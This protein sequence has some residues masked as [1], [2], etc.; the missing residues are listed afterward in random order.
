MNKVDA[1]L[2]TTFVSLSFLCVALCVL[3]GTPVLAA[4]N[5]QIDFYGTLQNESG[6]NL[7]G[8]YDIV[9]R[10]YDAPTGGTLLSTDTHTVANGNPVAV[11]NG[12]FAVVL[13]SGTGNSL[14]GIDFD[15]PTIYVGLTIASDTE[16]VP[17]ERLTA[18]P[19]AFNA[20]KVDGYHAA[21]LLRYNATGSMTASAADTLL[22]LRQNGI[23][24][25]F[26]LFGGATE[27]LSVLAN[28]R[29]GIGTTTPSR[30]FVVNGDAQFTGGLYDSLGTAGTLGMVLQTTGTTT[31]WVATSTLGISS[32]SGV[33]GMGPAGSIQTG[34]TLTLATSTSV[35]NGL[36]TGLLITGAGNTITYTPTLTGTLGN[37][38]LANSTIAFATGT[39]GSDVNWSTSPVALGGTA[40]LN[41]PNASATARGLLSS[42]DWNTFTGKISSTS[43]DT[44]AE[45]DTLITDMTGV[46]GS[47]SLVLSISPTFTGTTTLAVAIIASSTI[48]TLNLTSALS[49]Q[50]GGTGATSATGARTNLGATT[51][52]SNLFTLANPS[53]QTLIR[54][55]ADNTVS[56]IATSTLGIDLSDTTGSLPFSRLTNYGGTN[57]ILY[58]S[59]AG[60][61]ATS[62]ALTFDG[63]RLLTNTLAVTGTSTFAG[64]M[65]A[66]DIT[67]TGALRDTTNSAGTLGMVLQTTGTSTRWVAT[68]TL[69]IGGGSGDSLFTDGGATTYLTSLTDNLAIGTTTSTAKLA[70]V[71][72]IDLAS[73]NAGISLNGIR[74]FSGSSSLK[75]IQI[76][77]GAGLSFSN[78]LMIGNVAIGFEAAKNASTSSY[79][80]NVLIG[81]QTGMNS[82]GYYDVVIGYQ[83][84][85]NN[86]GGNN[87]AWASNVLIGNQA[88]YNNAGGDNVII[89]ELTGYQ[90]TGTSNVLL[91]FQAGYQN[92]SNDSVF[93]G[94]DAGNSAVGGSENIAIGF[95]AGYSMSGTGSSYLGYAAGNAA[96]GNQNTGIG[97]GALGGV[98]GWYNT[99][100]GASAGNV[101]VGDFNSMTGF[102]SGEHAIG[103]NNILLGSNAGRY[104]FG[105]NTIA[106]GAGAGTANSATLVDN[107]ES[108]Y[109]G[110]NAGGWAIAG[111]NNTFIGYDA[112][113]VAIGTRNVLLGSAAGSNAYATSSVF[114][115]DHA[116][117]LSQSYAATSSNVLI[118]SYSGYDLSG[119][120]YNNIIGDHAGYSSSNA[121][122]NNI[123]GY[124][125][126]YNLN[127]AAF[128][129]LQGYEAG[130]NMLA[131]SNTIAIGY[132]ALYGSGGLYDAKNNIALGYRA[133]YSAQAGANNN[134]LIGYNAGS[135]ILSGKSNIVIG[136]DLSLKSATQSNTM[137][138]G[139]LLYAT[140]LTAT[141]TATSTGKF[142]LGTSSPSAQLTTVGTV[143]FASFGAGTLQTDASGN[144]S[145]SSDERLKDIQSDFT[146]GIETLALI[147]PIQ[148]RWKTSTGYDTANVYT[149]FSAQNVQAVLPEA[150]GKSG[151]GYL[152]LSDRPLLA[153]VIN[154]IKEIYAWMHTTDTRVTTLEAHVTSLQSELDA[155]KAGKTN[156]SEQ[157]TTGGTSTDTPAVTSDDTAATTTVSAP[158]VETI[159]ATTPITE[160]SHEGSVDTSSGAADSGVEATTAAGS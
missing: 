59:A 15:S 142:G 51:V 40:T 88:G 157:T 143:R 4:I 160:E 68:S 60:V 57:T 56:S 91:G 19:Y 7:T 44:L 84:G 144:V 126:G 125:A 58:T 21:Q 148:Y 133:G 92:S 37:A 120:E 80:S 155:L 33:T 89:G 1:Y 70:V 71:G 43:L 45:L 116:G 38:G 118:G 102:Q 86:I 49:L 46:T 99:G 66:S 137:T 117:Y 104:L 23:G 81:Y 65:V 69:G 42:A 53:A 2:R 114:I 31:R 24:K 128:N 95:L 48:D 72:D 139:N 41:I 105:T 110:G 47:G 147:T 138:I 13:G 90:N 94:T 79:D 154:A 74:F 36:T 18:A 62:T 73:N 131:A 100:I 113:A 150:V 101:A 123:I 34:S 8:T 39:T 106:I 109:I 61:L 67:L 115:G 159:S 151:D 78:N 152:T 27:V 87:G 75:N 5:E 30:D 119:G 76:G 127:S 20:D 11:R 6:V 35:F 83:A 10:F 93:I 107:S 22:A 97:F 103:S 132:Q 64:G 16:M 82:S 50:N 54:I 32:S 55:N 158:T 112:G 85:F 153:T 25:I 9:F 108:I 156:L 146:K 141:G 121:A 17:R 122:Y 26:T 130:Y 149:G 12:M 135:N 145:V 111:P 63:T 14:A 124:N 96:I 98:N 77:E 29:V 136:D 28:G 134:I 52:G 129:E 3:V 140:G